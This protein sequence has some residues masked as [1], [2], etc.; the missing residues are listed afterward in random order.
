VSDIADHLMIAPIVLPLLAGAG[1]LLL[2]GE[3]H[4]NIMAAVN[5]AVTFAL[6]CIAIALLRASDASQTGIGQVY[7]LGDWS[8]PFGIVL[9][10]DRLAALMLLLT[11]I[12]ALAAVV[13]SLA[14]WHRAGAHFHPL[15]QF[16]LMGLNGAFLTGD[17]F[18]LFV[19]F[20]LLLAA[21]YGLLLHGSGL[22][23]VKAG[24]HY[25]VVNLVA[26]LLFLVGVSLIYGVTGTLNMA[27]LAARIPTIAA[28]NR[29]L[30]EAGAGIL[31]M[32]FLLKA[33]MWPLCFWLPTT[34][35]AASPP[36][37][38]IFAIMTKVGVYIVLRLSL[39][40]F[41]D[42]AGASA[43]FGS[44]WLLMGGLA[45]IVFGAIGTLA[46]Q[47]TARLA[48]FSVLVSSGTV[49][50]T[51]GMGQVGV[52]GGALFY[53]VSST[54]GVS[55]FFLLAELVERGR[56]PGADMIAVTRE[57]YGEDDDAGKG[58]EEVGI[59]IVATMGLLGVAF[60]GCALVIA[61]LP[62]LSGFIAKFA[63][64]T[65]A[66]H[67][68][69][70]HPGGAVP[71]SGWA[72]LVV[73]ISSGFATLVAMTRAGIRTFW[74]SPDRT[75]PRVRVIEIAAVMFLLIICAAQTIQAGPVM[76]F[77][78]ATAQSLHAPSGYI[79]NVVGTSGQST[80]KAGG[81]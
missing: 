17:L 66:L 38:S 14:R 52:T 40:L 63:L 32:A 12:L 70:M 51:T 4:R 74:T 33:G 58:E 3:R 30:L 34:Y 59:A 8:A 22:T 37:A 57:A 1:M 71:G 76:R 25:I 67:S 31:A 60:I 81:T 77:M 2:S 26:S 7:R 39:L 61:G 47:D 75:V 24:V 29:G 42:G 35:A 49:L 44:N 23:R 55:A 45:T 48:A 36:V 73:L 68:S 72:L 11:S 19:F 10:L 18:N 43:G 80:R 53:L 5:I 62:P 28:E 20:E 6:A 65:A 13:F 79:R 78:Q 69:E 15:F 64:L 9:V 16:L 50:A 46:S 41:G 27:D 54:L 56:E 21:S